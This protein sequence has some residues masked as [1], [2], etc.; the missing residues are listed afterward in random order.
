MQSLQELSKVH[1]LPE[2]ALKQLCVHL[3]QKV[4]M[5]P[6]VIELVPPGQPFF[7]DLLHHLSFF[8]RDPGCDFPI[9]ERVYRWE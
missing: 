4:G 2:D 5:P 7:L 6:D 9:A 1:P 3:V 8:A